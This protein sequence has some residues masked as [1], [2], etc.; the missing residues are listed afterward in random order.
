MYCIPTVG[1]NLHASEVDAMFGLAVG[2]V[3]PV[4]LLDRHHVQME[5]P[6]DGV[7]DLIRC[8]ISLPGLI[9]TLLS[10]GFSGALLAW[11]LLVLNRE[12]CGVTC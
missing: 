9:L 1:Y 12:L 3:S 7:A 10:V 4:R 5:S 11:S 2:A 8:S 6:L